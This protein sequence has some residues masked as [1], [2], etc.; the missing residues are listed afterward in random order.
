[1]RAC[2]SLVLASAAL[3][4][5]TV[6]GCGG[7]EQTATQR[8]VPPVHTATM[9]RD[10]PPRLRR[11]CASAARKGT[12]AVRCPRLVP[13]KSLNSS[14]LLPRRGVVR[15]GAAGDDGRRRFRGPRDFYVIEAYARSVRPEGHWLTGAGSPRSL[16]ERALVS[17]RPPR[18][19]RMRVADRDIELRRYPPYPDGG[20]NGGHVVA[21]ARDDKELVYVS[22][23]GHDHAD[24]AIAMLVDLLSPR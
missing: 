19:R 3:T 13:E 5:L 20:V 23:H 16:E 21:L 4:A 18:V 9:T 11:V 22:V 6:V 17:S 10:T 1:V 12:V 8:P 7:E 14:V 24:V 15:P 2:G